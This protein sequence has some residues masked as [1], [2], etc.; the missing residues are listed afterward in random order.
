MTTKYTLPQRL[1]VWPLPSS[2]S[3]SS[4]ALLSINFRDVS[5]TNSRETQKLARTVWPKTHRPRG[6]IRPRDWDWFGAWPNKKFFASLPTQSVRIRW[7][8]LKKIICF[9]LDN[10]DYSHPLSLSTVGEPSW[11][12]FLGTISKYRKKIKTS[13][14]LAYVLNKT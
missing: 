14:S 12:W 13:S 2:C 9:L 10:R 3:T 6:V 11:S 7:T 1:V 5:E 4:R 8:A